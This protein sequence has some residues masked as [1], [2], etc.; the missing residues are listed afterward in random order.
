[1]QASNLERGK[2]RPQQNVAMLSHL[3]VSHDRNRLQGQP[4]VLR[5]RARG[6]STGTM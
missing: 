6:G 5:V 3:D 2:T 1:M 4:H